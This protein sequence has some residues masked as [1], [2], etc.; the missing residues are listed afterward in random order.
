MKLK[1]FT[2]AD[3][4]KDYS[5][6]ATKEALKDNKLIGNAIMLATS[7][8][9]VRKEYGLPIIIDSVDLTE[10]TADIHAQT[11]Y[12][13]FRHIQNCHGSFGSVIVYT[14]D[15]SNVMIDDIMRA[16]HAHHFRVS[17]PDEDGETQSL[18]VYFEENY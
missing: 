1:Y 4:F 14:P 18:G 3:F 11:M 12:E 16:V 6:E 7:L 8:D 9:K 15:A 10:G 2:I 13:L 17:V 5:S